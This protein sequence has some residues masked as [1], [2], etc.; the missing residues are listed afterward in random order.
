MLKILLLLPLFTYGASLNITPKSFD[1]PVYGSEETVKLSSLKGKKTLI[2]FWASW[3]T[4]C[5]E[6]LPDLHAL[7]KSAK[8]SGYE[9]I[10][11]NA[12]DTPKKIKRFIKRNKFNYKILQDRSREISKSWGVDSLPITVILDETGKVIYKGTRPPKSLL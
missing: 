5:I 8:S 10:A 3:C 9:F 1:L 4:S 2:N 12:G 11:I 7:K 6:E